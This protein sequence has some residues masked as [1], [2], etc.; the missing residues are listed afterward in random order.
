MITVYAIETIVS[1]PQIRNGRP[2][3]AGTQIR[4]MDIV[5][6]H[7][8]RGLSPEALAVN[9]RLKLE[10]VYAA[11]AYYYQFKDEIDTQLREEAALANRYLNELDAQGK[12]IRLD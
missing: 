11:L 5:A 6:S 4:V 9:F 3:I 12:L 10:Q 2:I 7:L 1:D 8:F